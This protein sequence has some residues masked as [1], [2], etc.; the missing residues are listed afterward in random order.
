MNNQIEVPAQLDPNGIYY[1]PA[2]ST[3]VEIRRDK[4]QR[5]EFPPDREMRLEL[6]PNTH[7]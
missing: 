5:T 4:F 2:H 6:E 1:R 3:I 7:K